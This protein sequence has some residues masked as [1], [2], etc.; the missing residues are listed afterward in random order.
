VF[1]VAAFFL[2]FLLARAMICSTD[3]LLICSLVSV[4]ESFFVDCF[5]VPD[6]LVWKLLDWVE[7]G[8]LYSLWEN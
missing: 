3:M 1:T 7:N 2:P 8:F 6:C 4:E 5:D